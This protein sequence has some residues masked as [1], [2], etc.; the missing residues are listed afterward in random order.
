V[1][2]FHSSFNEWFSFLFLSDL[3]GLNG[4]IPFVLQEPRSLFFV[5]I[6]SVL[7]VLTGKS[8]WISSL[9]LSVFSF[10][11]GW[12][13]V[14]KI[15]VHWPALKYPALVS[16]LY[17]PTSVFWS[18][19][20]L[21][22]SLAYG[23]LMMIGAL[24]IMGFRTRSANWRIMVPGFILLWMLWSVKYHYAVLIVL[25]LA[26]GIT[27]N[28]LY[29]VKRIQY[30][31]ALFLFIFILITL[32]LS[33]LH[34]NFHISSL[35][36]VLHA[37]QEKIMDQSNEKNLITFLPI[38][39]GMIHFI[40]NVPVSLVAGLFMPLPW[41]GTGYFLQATG[42][43]NLFVLLL[44]IWKLFTIRIQ[45]GNW[46]HWTVILVIYILILAVFT[47]YATPNFGTLERYK[48]GYL[49]FFLCWIFRNH[50]IFSKLKR[51]FKLKFW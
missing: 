19:G 4:E 9:F 31:I 33:R 16:F 8:Y 23:C 34:P 17:F 26:S 7:Y 2:S 48:T 37:N 11:G 49:P 22:D 30:R 32:G 12:Y 3:S 40:V 35:I 46:S 24:I 47:A 44:M 42:F 6:L 39:T 15:T 51:V 36:D 18:S 13:I 29:R 10:W 5:K 45:S 14:K 27:W 21:K 50:F 43:L 20:V 25:S 41:Q 1:E 38:G 28:A